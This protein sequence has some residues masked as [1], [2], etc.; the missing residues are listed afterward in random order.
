MARS[1][2]TGTPGNTDHQTQPAAPPK[3]EAANAPRS[4]T[5]AIDRVLQ[6]LDG[7]QH[8]NRPMTAYEIAQTAGAP[9]STMYTIINDLVDKSLLTRA[10]DG[11]IW[12]GPRLY[13]YGLTYAHSL[14]YLAIAAEEM[15]RLSADVEETVQIC[16]REDGMMIVLQMAEGPGHFRVTSRVGSRVPINWAASGR[17]LVGHLDDGEREDF[18]RRYGQPSP[19][20]L[21]ETR[22]DVL[23]RIAQ[24]SFAAR[25]ALQ[26]G[27]S[28][29]S[30]ACLAS[31]VCNVGGECVITI[32]IVMPEN[33]AK[34]G[35]D[36]YSAAVR[37]AAARIEDRLGWR[38]GA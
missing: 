17:L 31:P 26:I 8:A 6:I 25:F 36:R 10:A 33:K 13:R 14:D 27:E 22:P 7:L 12:F 20:G 34:Q 16:G 3:D 37:D 2:N 11:T 9:A 4:R 29:A 32:S 24:E 19:T 1:R 21:A 23:S 38:A 28:E 15:Q 18:F 35:I 30:V 5:G